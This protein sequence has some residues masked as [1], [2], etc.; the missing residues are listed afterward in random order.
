[1]SCPAMAVSFKPG[2]NNCELYYLTS[3]K[4]HEGPSYAGQVN[5]TLHLDCTSQEQRFDGISQHFINTLDR[6][7]VPATANVYI[8][9]YSMGSKGR[10]FSIAENMGLIKHK[11]WKRGHHLT[12]VP[13]SVVKKAATGKG[14]AKKEQMYEAFVR[15]TGVKFAVGKDIGSPFS[16]IVDAYYISEYGWTVEK[17]K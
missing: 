10:V 11:L 3:T 4:K 13:P 15:D 9:G 8:E 1:M 7:K 6:L 2:W 14:N 16:D 17:A 5:G 12:E